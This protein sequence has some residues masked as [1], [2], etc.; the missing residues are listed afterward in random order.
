MAEAKEVLRETLVVAFKPT[1]NSL[2]TL[3]HL[4][5]SVSKHLIAE[6]RVVKHIQI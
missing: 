2:I 3:K 1:A 6:I 5:K 4:G